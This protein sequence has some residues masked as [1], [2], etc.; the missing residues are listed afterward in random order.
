MK[1]RYEVPDMEI[2]VVGESIVTSI[3]SDDQ[4]HCTY[5]NCELDF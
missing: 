1:E 4:L 2:V 5:D 3:G